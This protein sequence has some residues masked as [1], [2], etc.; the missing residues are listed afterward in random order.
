MVSSAFVIYFYVTVTQLCIL[1]KI[2]VEIST[3]KGLTD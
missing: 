1:Y 3:K 2:M